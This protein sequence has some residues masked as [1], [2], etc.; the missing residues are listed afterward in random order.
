MDQTPNPIKIYGESVLRATCEDVTFPNPDLNK[1][2]LSMFLI[3]YKSHGVGL[4][5]NQIGL[6]IRVAVI[7][8]DPEARADEQIILIN[9]SIINSEGE[10]E[11]E[12]GCLSIPGISAPRKRAE[13]ITVETSDLDGETYTFEAE[14]LLAVA[15]Q[16]EIDHLN[17]KF[18]VDEISPMNKILI[19]NKLKRM[20]RA[21]KNQYKESK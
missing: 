9:P 14:G 18:F 20:A 10:Q 3:M 17:G 16:H 6:P 5:A 15:C 4:A 2:I 1:I 11:A 7:N 13:K 19:Q 12:E 8:V 21:V